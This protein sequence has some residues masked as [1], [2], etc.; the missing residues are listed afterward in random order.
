L[1]AAADA[2]GAPGTDPRKMGDFYSACMITPAID[3]KVGPM[4]NLSEPEKQ[5]LQ[6]L[7]EPS[8]TS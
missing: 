2:S 4:S 8:S 5:N 1:D 7:A 3:A 6:P